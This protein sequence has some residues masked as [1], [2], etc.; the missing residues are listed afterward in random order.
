MDRRTFVK[1]GLAASTWLLARRQAEAQGISGP[2]VV[3]V[4]GESAYEITRRALSE[5]GG[6]GRFVGR[7]DVVMVKPNIAWNRSPE[8]AGTTNPDV[9]RAVV[10]MVLAAGA[11]KAIVMD[12]A[13]HQ[14]EESYARSGIAAAARLA[15]AEVRFTDDNR[16]VDFDFKGEYMQKWPV[17]RDFIEVDKFINVPIL[18]HHSSSGLT[19]AMK[20]LYGI[21]GGN[22]GKLHRDMGYNIADMAG[23]WKC[24]LTVIDAY[25][26]LLRN[27]PVGG[28][29]SDVELKKTVIASTGIV[30]ADTAAAVLFGSVPGQLE[31]L[32]AAAERKLGET[33]PARLRIRKI[34]A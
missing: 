24:H 26:V 9:V 32:Q 27:G 2:A 21:L 28:R 23:G 1:N 22:R 18:K 16:L 19:I 3:E 15:G 20:N 6:M 11:K 12:H 5:L 7:G 17:Y 25:R 34:A 10:E 14:A 8:L 30:E 4:R 13:T 29:P 31:F 33:D